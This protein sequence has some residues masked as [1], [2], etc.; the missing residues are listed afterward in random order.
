MTV[1]AC[2]ERTKSYATYPNTT[3]EG[4]GPGRGEVVAEHDGGWEAQGKQAWDGRCVVYVW[5]RRRMRCGA[6]VKKPPHPS[7]IIYSPAPTPFPASS[8]M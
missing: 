3:G 7:L 8:R 2:F 1:N 4:V 5:V 6:I